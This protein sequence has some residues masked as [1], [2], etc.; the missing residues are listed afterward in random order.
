VWRWT[1]RRGEEVKE[2]GRIFDEFGDDGGKGGTFVWD[3]KEVVSKVVKKAGAAATPPPT[4]PEP[5]LPRD[6]PIRKEA[7]AARTALVE[8]LSTHHL[9]LLEEFFDLPSPETEADIPSHLLVS[10]SSLRSAIRALTLSGQALPVL[11]GSAFK[12]IGVEVL[13]DAVR[14]YLPSPGDVGGALVVGGV[15][16]EDLLAAAGSSKGGGAAK[17]GAKKGGWKGKAKKG[18]AVAM[19]E[20]E[21]EKTVEVDDSRVCALAFK[22]VWDDQKGWM[23]FVR[24]YS[25]SSSV[26]PS[27]LL[28]YSSWS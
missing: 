23:T 20:G 14:D 7:I 2:E 22:V 11:C 18:G 24:V 16:E 3:V 27:P 4:P 19:N 17:K 1:G 25:G 15:V 6:H 5:F 28:S 12:G 8:T 9:P 21:Q 26:L 10:P 13:L